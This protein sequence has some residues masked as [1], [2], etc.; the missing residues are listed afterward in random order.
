MIP[1]S[2]GGQSELLPRYLRG[3]LLL[4]QGGLNLFVTQQ[5]P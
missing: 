1:L 4:D 2:A 3:D 5:G